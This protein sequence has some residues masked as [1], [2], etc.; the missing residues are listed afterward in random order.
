VPP[1]RAEGA[2]KLA[3]G[4]CRGAIHCKYMFLALYVGRPWRSARKLWALRGT[5][6]TTPPSH[7]SLIRP[8]RC[9]LSFLMVA[10]SSPR[11]AHG[12]GVERPIPPLMIPSR[13]APVL[14]R[15]YV[16][17]DHVTRS[18]CPGSGEHVTNGG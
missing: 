5:T 16:I 15:H 13:R 17:D 7:P 9:D 10:P 2:Y 8:S 18:G 11:A 1:I 14:P 3:L 6:K 4:R 12:L